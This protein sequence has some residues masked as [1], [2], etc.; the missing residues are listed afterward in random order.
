MSFELKIDPKRRASGRFI[1]KVRRVLVDAALAAKR[2]DKMSQAQVAQKL[3]VDRST[4]TRLLK[5]EANLTL[6]TIGEIAWALGLEPHFSLSRRKERDRANIGDVVVSASS[7]DRPKAST[8]TTG[9][10]AATTVVV[11]SQPSSIETRSNR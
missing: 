11:R 8:T 10:G 1:G 2:E 6:R 7:D 5:G 4:I 3:G 9:A